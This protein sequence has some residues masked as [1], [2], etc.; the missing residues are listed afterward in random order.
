MAKMKDFAL[1][2]DTSAASTES[3]LYVYE[4]DTV[5]EAKDKLTELNLTFGSGYIYCATIGQKEGAE[6][7][8]FEIERTDNGI[9]WRRSEDEPAYIAAQDKRY[10]NPENW[11]R[12]DEWETID[13]F[14]K[15]PEK[16]ELP[17]IDMKKLEDALIKSGFSHKEVQAIWHTVWDYSGDW[18]K[19]TWNPPSYEKAEVQPV[20]SKASELSEQEWKWTNS[21]DKY[22]KAD[23]QPVWYER[24]GEVFR[25]RNET[26]YE[27]LGIGDN[28]SVIVRSAGG[29]VCEA[30]GLQ[31]Y[32]DGTVEW[33]NSGNTHH[34][35]P[36]GR[37]ESENREFKMVRTEE[38]QTFPDWSD[39][40]GET[41][42]S[43]YGFGNMLTVDSVDGIH[44]VNF[45]DKKGY[46]YN[47][48]H[49]K[50]NE[51]GLI[52]WE[53]GAFL[54]GRKLN[55]KSDSIT[56]EGHEG[57]WYVIESR[58]DEESNLKLFLL[59]HEEHGDETASVIVD[60]Y[61]KIIL[62]DVWNGFEDY[63][64]HKAGLEFD[65]RTA[66]IPPEER[67]IDTLLNVVYPEKQD[68]Q[69]TLQNLIDTGNYDYICVYNKYRDFL[70]EGNPQELRQDGLWQLIDEQNAKVGKSYSGISENGKMAMCI[71]LSNFPIKDRSN[72]QLQEQLV[73]LKEN[74]EKKKILEKINEKKTVKEKTVKNK[75]KSAPNKE[76]SKKKKETAL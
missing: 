68:N 34:T 1:V 49:P 23:V 19:A 13:Q 43:R 9:D 53:G 67:N 40:I 46:I 57:T 32:K 76:S 54:D 41:Y 45:V 2:I 20:T 7:R 50:L 6:N 14:R 56:V 42:A 59:E 17:T 63:E 10:Y 48:L 74:A 27:I 75:E 15:A 11:S 64:E 26:E 5:R 60:S 65:E 61:G 25:N 47:A 62:D 38:G 30:Y 71:V 72:E 4:A 16:E 51:K 52:E 33:D 22:E 58:T 73:Y 70:A 18:L 3:K 21:F 24:V 28:H 35:F 36:D 31:M 44:R 37:F 8:Y 55:E 66:H 12:V 39:K 29:W 69:D